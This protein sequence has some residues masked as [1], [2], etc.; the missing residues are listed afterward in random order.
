MGFWV[1]ILVDYDVILM[2][3]PLLRNVKTQHLP[4]SLKAFTIDCWKWYQTI[5]QPRFTICILYIVLC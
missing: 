4:L 3:H 2:V 1:E 5:C